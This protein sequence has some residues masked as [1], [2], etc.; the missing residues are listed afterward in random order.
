LPLP[1]DIPRPK[2]R[3]G[4]AAL[5][6]TE[7]ASFWEP[8]GVRAVRVSS[9]FPA[10]VH[11][12]ETLW[13]DTRSWPGWVDGLA[14]VT[15]VSADWPAAGARVRWQS[16]P[17]GRG[18]VLERV[19]AHEALRGQ[20]VEV[21]DDSVRGRQS[22]SFSPAPDGVEVELRLE[23]EVRRRSLFTWLVDP[24]FIRSAVERSLRA[25]L[26]RFGAELGATREP[27]VE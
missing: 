27:G 15:E 20:T 24:L 4:H 26:A 6:G 17:A 5:S 8:S 16:G 22:V 23:Y 25:T 21:E 11:E 10:T 19:V 13:Y 3:H 9:T 1:E 14:S 12:A 7:P 18:Q 2:V